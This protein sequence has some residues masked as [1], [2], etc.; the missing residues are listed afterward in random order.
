MSLDEQRFSKSESENEAR[1]SFLAKLSI[2]MSGLI[3][4]VMV[5]PGIGFVVAPALRRSKQKWRSV[6]KVE[7]FTV[8]ST[9]L[10][11][12]EDPSPESWAGVTAKTGAWLRRVSE[13]E[14]IA[15]S[16]NCRHLG[17]PVRWVD[18]ARLFMCPCHG[19]VYYEDGTV[20]G[21]PPPKPLERL[22]V[23]LRKGEVEIETGAVP[24]TLTKV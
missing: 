2:M 22:V 4:M 21:G 15:F 24:L 20:A 17:C 23:R 11:S 9:V 7:E 10:V 12:Y 1:R 5:L 16:I 18:D 6:G 3:G 13:K 14:F 8:G 19:G